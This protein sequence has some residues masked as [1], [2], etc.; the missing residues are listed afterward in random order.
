MPF[1]YYYLQADGAGRTI[2]A[3]SFL[4]LFINVGEIRKRNHIFRSPAFICWSLLVLYAMINSYLKGF[5]SE[6]GTLAF[7]KNNYI[8]PFVFLVV[9]IIELD[10]NQKRSYRVLLI[11]LMTF[12][13]IGIRNISVA[14]D[15][16]M[17][18]EG[19]GNQLPLNAVCAI[20]LSSFLYSRYRMKNIIYYILVAM[21]IVLIVASGTRKALGAAVIILIGTVLSKNAK[22]S[23]SSIIRTL[24]FGVLLYFGIGYI[25]DHTLIGLRIMESSELSNVVFTED[26]ELNDFLLTILGDRAIMY[27]DSWM[28]WLKHPIS[29]IGIMNYTLV[30]G[31]SF[32]LHTEYMVQLCENGLIGFMLL[33]MTYYHLYKG[34]RGRGQLLQRDVL[35]GLFTFISLLFLN[36]TA[37][38][39]SAM[40]GMIF[41]GILFNEAYSKLKFNKQ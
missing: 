5:Q 35:M 41:Y 29:G 30:S 10:T 6:W 2:L 23:F 40:F 16:R 38:T 17:L 15:E 22:L 36:I 28:I 7:Y 8:N 4:A 24:L 9:L 21:L 32:R 11:S 31:Y 18:A 39:Y 14:I 37:W 19:I 27:W 1:Q 20:L 3:L 26:R 34:I 12:V 13:Y 25:L 33:M